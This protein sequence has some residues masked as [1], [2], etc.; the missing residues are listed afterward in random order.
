M[1]QFSQD[2]TGPAWRLGLIRKVG[3]AGADVL[4]TRSFVPSYGFGGTMQNQEV[5]ARL[6][7]PLGRRVYTTSMLSWRRDDPLT[8]AQLPLRSYWIEGSIGYAV[9]PWV[10]FEAF[11]AGTY[12][13]IDR[14]GGA[15]DRN[16]VGLQIMTAKP[17]RIR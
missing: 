4:Y 1:T 9:T 13:T 7:L 8:V 11:Y 14:P 15:L 2:R 17:V 5:T 16:R 12:Q 3:R 10:R 6:Q